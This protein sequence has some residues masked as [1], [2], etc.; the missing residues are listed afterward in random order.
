MAIKETVEREVKLRAGEAFQLPELGGEAIEPRLFVST[1][2]DTDDH[3]LARRG[4]TLRHRVEN[5]KGLWQLKL[6]HGV[7]AARARGTGRADGAA[8]GAAGAPHRPSSRRPAAADRPPAHASRGRPRRRRRDRP[9]HGRRARPPAGHATFRGARGGA[10][11]RRREDA[12]AAREGAPPRGRR[13]RREQA[14]GLPG[15]RSRLPAGTGRGRRRHLGGGRPAHAPPRAGRAAARAR[16]RHA[17]RHRPGGAAPAAGGDAAAA[18]VP[19]RRPRPA[20]PRDGGAAPRRAP[21][22]RRRARPG[23]RPRRP[24]RAPR[25]RGARPR[26][27]RDG[28]PEA[29]AHARSLAALGAPPPAGRARQRALLRAARHARAARSRPSRTSRRSTRSVPRSTRGCARR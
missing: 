25:R 11:R 24:D 15:A 1:Y 22:A 20:R 12:A 5:G 19:P 6:P 8:G 17:A 16:S 28:G 4:I 14:Q 13:R 3:R 21:L 26:S 27:G 29:R 7:C 23:P 10:S 9:R 18:G 2:H